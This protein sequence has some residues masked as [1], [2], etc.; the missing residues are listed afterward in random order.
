VGEGKNAYKVLAGKPFNY[1][2]ARW[3]KALADNKGKRMFCH[4]TV[5]NTDHKTHDYPILKKLGMKIEK[6]TEATTGMQLLAWPKAIR[7]RHLLQLPQL[8]PLHPRTT[9]EVPVHCL[10]GSQ[11]LRDWVRMTPMTNMIT[12]GNCPE[13]CIQVLALNDTTVISM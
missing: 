4:N 8:I 2:F 1:H 7:H 11:S 13:P 5:R 6:W 10:G 12:K 9:L 3:K